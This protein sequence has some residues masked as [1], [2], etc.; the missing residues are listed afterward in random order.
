MSLIGGYVDP[1]YAADDYGLQVDM[2]AGGDLVEAPLSPGFVC[3]HSGSWDPAS[4]LRS[5]RGICWAWRYCAG[6]RSRMT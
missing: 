1:V 5:A 6:R 4:G 2:G 3:C